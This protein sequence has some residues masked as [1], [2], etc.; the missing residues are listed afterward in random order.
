MFLYQRELCQGVTLEDL[1]MG[2]D[3]ILW[4]WREQRQPDLRLSTKAAT[5]TRALCTL[6]KQTCLLLRQK[7]SQ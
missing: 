5:G 1:G 3:K 4:A 6:A 2:E 7:A